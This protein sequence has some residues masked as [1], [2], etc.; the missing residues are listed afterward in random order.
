MGSPTALD[1]IL[2]LLLGLALP[3]LS[4]LGGRDALRGEAYDRAE[5]FAL[6]RGNSIALW[7][8]AAVVCG[9][10]LLADRPLSGLGLGVPNGSWPAGLLACALATSFLVDSWLQLRTP[11]RRRQTHERARR[12]TP[13]LPASRAEFAPYALLAVSAGVCEEVLFR[14]HLIRY[15]QALVGDCP[16]QHVIAVGLPAVVF[17]LV[18]LY[19]GWRTVAKIGLGAAALGT[20]FVLSGSLWVCMALHIAIDLVGGM[21]ALRLES[22]GAAEQHEE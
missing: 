12:D 2:A 10:W 8:A 7:L 17:A 20:I 15:V 11:E 13:F 9:V 21:L 18:H 19:Q 3:I 1:H 16:L 6:Y 14:G 4:L 22:L 5:K